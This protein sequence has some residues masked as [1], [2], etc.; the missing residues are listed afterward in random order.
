MSRPS[1]LDGPYKF[2]EQMFSFPPASPTHPFGHNLPELQLT[3]THTKTTT[4]PQTPRSP[5]P[6]LPPKDLFRA[7]VRRVIALHRGTRFIATRNA[8]AEP[9]VDPRRANAD[10]EYGEIQQKCIIEVA[11]YSAVRCSL[12]RMTNQEFVDFMQETSSNPRQPWVKVRWINIG[13][14]SYDVIKAMSMVY[15]LHPLALEDV[16]HAHPRARSKTD[17]YAQHL[18]MRILCH[19]LESSAQQSPDDQNHLD[20]FL[21]LPVH[22]PRTRRLFDLEEIRA[23]SAQRRMQAAALAA[24]KADERVNVHVA[25]MCIFL[26]RDGTV[27]TIHSTPNL[28][29]TQP[30]TTRVLQFKTILRTSADASL[31][32]QSLL[33]LV[34]DE[35]FE[36]ITAYQEKIK[37]LERIILAKPSIETVRNLHILSA[38]LMLHRRTLAPL[39][40]LIYGLRRYDADRAAALLDLDNSA[41]DVREPGYM[42]RRSLIYLA[43]VHDQ[44]EQVLSQLD[45]IAGI[46]E[47]LVDYT[48]NMTSYEL[49]EVMRRLMLV[50]VIFLPLTVVAGYF[51]MNF[52]FMWSTSTQSDALYWAVALPIL[53][54]LVPIFTAPDLQRIRHEIQKR[55]LARKA[56]KALRG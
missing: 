50:T 35:A 48:F 2:D 33:G 43:D 17:Y 25:P 14:I 41:E 46:G 49:N 5:P 10:A 11:D 15:D 39:K 18:F 4:R 47:N 45:V 29:M 8:G 6:F 53:A 37:K 32:V 12:S 52:T 20:E 27:I 31:L 13:G 28:A 21:P 23:A 55:F 26:F 34:T 44:I 16:F 38:D 1:S 40:T 30:I 54:V 42:S 36:V 51:G 9:G 7:A 3:R 56:E 19:E 24:L 22:S